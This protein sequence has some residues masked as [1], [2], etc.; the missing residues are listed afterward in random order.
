LWGKSQELCIPGNMTVTGSQG[1]V[2]TG[3]WDT[4]KRLEKSNDAPSVATKDDEMAQLWDSIYENGF[5]VAHVLGHKAIC[6][7]V[8]E[9]K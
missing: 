8:I 9:S 6:A 3:R 1:E 4:V 7:S 5:Y 2:F